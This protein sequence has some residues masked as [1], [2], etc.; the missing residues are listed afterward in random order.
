[1]N[2]SESQTHPIFGQNWGENKEKPMPRE[3]EGEAEARVQALLAAL[4]APIV[5]LVACSDLPTLAHASDEAA[6]TRVVA[7]TKGP[8]EKVPIDVRCVA[9]GTLREQLHSPL[10]LDPWTLIARVV[11]RVVDPAW[12]HHQQQQQQHQQQHQLQQPRGHQPATAAAA[13]E[14]GDGEGDTAP[15]LRAISEEGVS[16]RTF[17]RFARALSN[18]SPQQRAQLLAGLLDA[19]NNGR[20]ETS[21]AMKRMN[22]A[23]DGISGGPR[24]RARLGVS[25]GVPPPESESGPVRVGVLVQNAVSVV[26]AEAMRSVEEAVRR[27]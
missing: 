16:P 22:A 1:L 6:W 15:W 9:L 8:W 26:T 23:G 2:L 5:T 12:Q 3:T 4:P 25:V 10:V 19:R 21:A 7:L 18:G 27:R 17:L 13:A 14:E 20:P 11:E 24:K